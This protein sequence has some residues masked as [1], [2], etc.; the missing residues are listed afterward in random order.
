MT[1]AETLSEKVR[2][3]G[4]R[5]AYGACLFGCIS[6]VMLDSSAIIII[7]FTMLDGGDMLTMLGF[8]RKSWGCNSF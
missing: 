7:F 5:Y 8:A 6:E 3:S 2:R 4:R 1:Y